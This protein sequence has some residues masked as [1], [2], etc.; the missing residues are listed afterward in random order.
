MINHRL[1]LSMNSMVR[2]SLFLFSE[3]KKITKRF[4]KLDAL[5][6]ALISHIE[7]IG[8]LPHAHRCLLVFQLYNPILSPRR[9]IPSRIV[10]QMNAAY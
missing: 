2:S 8:L 6:T 10:E 5:I 3:R 9:Q 4:S 7:L 1:Q